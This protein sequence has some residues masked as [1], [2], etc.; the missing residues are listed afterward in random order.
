[1]A[2]RMRVPH[3]HEHGSRAGLEP[4]ERQGRGRQQLIDV[5]LA[6]GGRGARPPR[7]QGQDRCE[8]GEGGDPRP[9]RTIAAGEQRQHGADHEQ[10]DRP[11][12]ERQL[13]AAYPQV[14]R[15][16][17]REIGAPPP[18]SCQGRDL[19][20]RGGADRHG[21][22]PRDPCHLS[23]AHDQYHRDRRGEEIDQVRL[24]AETRMRRHQRIRQPPFVGNA[25]QDVAA[26][27]QRHLAGVGQRDHRRHGD[28]G[29]D[30][31]PQ[32]VRCREV[33]GD[34]QERR[35][36]PERA[37]DRPDEG[38]EQE[39]RRRDD[40]DAERGR[41][42]GHATQAL[43]PRRRQFVRRPRQPL[44]AAR[45]G[46]RVSQSGER[47]NHQQQRRDRAIPPAETRP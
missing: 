28:C 40:H 3:R 6:R 19:Q 45:A 31:E 14:Q 24:R 33:L 35:L 9:C 36:D 5:Q 4:I 21:V 8:A 22:G 47:G 11:Q 16:A 20:A 29:A 1:M 42:E 43:D 25:E 30:Q 13:A 12:P 23:A 26:L 7:R 38:G 18:Q 27:C 17:K 41:D 34:P 10:T 46:E 15:Y 39:G 32:P 2:E 37:A 44:A